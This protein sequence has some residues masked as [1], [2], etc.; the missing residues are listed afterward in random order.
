M[1]VMDSLPRVQGVVATLL[2]DVLSVVTLP[3]RWGWSGCRARRG[4][5]RW[6]GP[7]F[8]AAQGPRR[9][10]GSRPAAGRRRRR[11]AAA[12]RPAGRPPGEDSGGVS[13]LRWALWL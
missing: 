5:G 12:L 10:G 8:P 4:A 2:A 9:L 13:R 3:G 6:P 11:C 7:W 1:I